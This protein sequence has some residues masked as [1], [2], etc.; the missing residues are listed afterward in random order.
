MTEDIEREERAIYVIITI[1]CLPVVVAVL[2]EGG[3]FDG[4][5]SLSLMMAIDALVGLA[6]LGLHGLR[7]RRRRLPHARIHQPSSRSR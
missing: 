4:G 6:G 5:A 7:G 2:L 1:A 3:A